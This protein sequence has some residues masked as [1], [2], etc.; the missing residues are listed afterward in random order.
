MI[1]ILLFV[2]PILAYYLEL[3]I[4]GYRA[5]NK[6]ESQTTGSNISVTWKV[7]ALHTVVSDHLHLGVKRAGCSRRTLPLSAGTKQLATMGPHSVW[8]FY[9]RRS[10]S[11]ELTSNYNPWPDLP[12][13]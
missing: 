8:D 9:R 5:S 13:T 2:V 3:R 10:R 4:K 6:I 1:T 7:A 11:Q 12:S